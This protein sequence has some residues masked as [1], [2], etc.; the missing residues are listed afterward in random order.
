MVLTGYAAQQINAEAPRVPAFGQL[1]P[2]L[3][4]GFRSEGG[5][6]GR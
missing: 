2:G 6:V 1:H 3:L 4:F 5:G